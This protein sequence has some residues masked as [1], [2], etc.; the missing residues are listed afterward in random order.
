MST[1]AYTTKALLESNTCVMLLLRRWD[2]DY[3]ELYS[4]TLSASHSFFGTVLAIC[5]EILQ[6]LILCQ[7]SS[8]YL[9]RNFILASCWRYLLIW[10][11]YPVYQTGSILISRSWKPVPAVCLQQL[12][13]THLTSR[14]RKLFLLQ[15][16]ELL[17]NLFNIQS[18][19]RFQAMTWKQEFPR[20]LFSA[21]LALPKSGAYTIYRAANYLTTVYFAQA[22]YWCHWKSKTNVLLLPPA[23]T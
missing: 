7:I 12:G 17:L 11:A 2:N 20:M 15:G 14:S 6:M 9:T 3:T 19:M 4:E 5:F 1:K 18:L 23:S 21:C 22:C 16:D 10:F 13:I 8:M